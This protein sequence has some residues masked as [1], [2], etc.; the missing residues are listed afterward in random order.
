VAW[1]VVTGG[2]E[3]LDAIRNKD[4]FGVTEA[5][6]NFSLSLLGMVNPVSAGGLIAV[7]LLA[8]WYRAVEAA[9]EGAMSGILLTSHIPELAETTSCNLFQGGGQYRI[10][11]TSRP[12]KCRGYTRD[13][14]VAGFAWHGGR[15]VFIDS[16]GTILPVRV[17][18]EKEAREFRYLLQQMEYIQGNKM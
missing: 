13:A 1:T 15:L 3:I 5:T 16:R 11:M 17:T 18:T 2:Y 12:W 10:D 14:Q 6:A 8:G 9:R 7:K 4:P